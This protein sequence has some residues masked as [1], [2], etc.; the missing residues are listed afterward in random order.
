MTAQPPKFVG[1]AEQAVPVEIRRDAFDE[2]KPQGKP[3][4]SSVPLP[5]GDTAVVALSAVRVDPSGDPKEQETQMR[6]E[7]AQAAAAV[8]AQGYAAAARADAKVSLNL[9]AIE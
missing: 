5:A 7:F 6:R 8:E 3:V 1:R 2:P 9:Q 4:Y